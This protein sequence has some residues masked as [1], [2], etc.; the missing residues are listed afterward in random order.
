MT[1]A[2]NILSTENIN[3]RIVTGIIFFPL[4]IPL[5]TL[6]LYFFL[7]FASTWLGDTIPRWIFVIFFSFWLSQLL[8]HIFIIL[9][10]L[11]LENPALR[12]ITVW[13]TDTSSIVIQYALL[14]YMVWRS[15]SISDK[16]RAR[17][18][19]TFAFIYLSEYIFLDIITSKQL[20]A[21]IGYPRS[22]L[23]NTIN[24]LIHLAPMFYLIHF[25]K[26]YF[27]E[28]FQLSTDSPVLQDFFIEHSI[29]KREQEVIMLL[30]KGKSNRE[31]ED[32]LYISL[33]T[34]KNHLYN[35]Y[36]KT[37]VKNRFQLT[38]LISKL[39]NTK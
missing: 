36:H 14:L 3:T 11:D 12:E 4:I 26:S 16:P 39:N 10:I 35:I 37:E 25:I 5:L 32:K 38:S 23:M 2:T 18:I 9:S 22:F 28:P 27:Q 21:W 24:F 20:T 19:R 33:G 34:V 30:L 8:L 7:R 13:L 29:S 1:L 17:G 6:T 31:I 15:R